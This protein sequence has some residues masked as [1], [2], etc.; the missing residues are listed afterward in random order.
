MNYVLFQASI[1]APV[2]STFIPRTAHLKMVK[3][4]VV[5]QAGAVIE[6][7]DREQLVRRG[8][9]KFNDLQ[10]VDVDCGMF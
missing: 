5:T 3:P 9:V 8:I 6:P 10:E 2:G 7:M 4:R 1:R